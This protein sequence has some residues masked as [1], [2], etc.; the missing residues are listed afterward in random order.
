MLII[1]RDVKCWILIRVFIR[2]GGVFLRDVLVLLFAALCAGWRS[3]PCLVSLISRKPGFD[4]HR[5]SLLCPLQE[6]H[7]LHVT[8]LIQA[9]A[10]QAQE[11]SQ[12]ITTATTYAQQSAAVA[13]PINTDT[14]TTTTDKF[15]LVNS[16]V[17]THA[18][19]GVSIGTE[20]VDGPV[21]HEQQSI[22]F[23]AEVS[24]TR[25]VRRKGRGWRRWGGEGGITADPNT[26]PLV[27]ANPVPHLPIL[28]SF[29]K[30]F[31]PCTHLSAQLV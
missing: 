15:P 29:V 17:E 9:M 13:P 28:A 14:T 10:V 2:F 1:T 22:A 18:G 5:C 4:G 3:R 7:L 6:Q 11:L 26:H 20:D 8:E 30:T 23:T 25:G 16:E 24:L 12:S 31:I 27:R 19:A 21:H